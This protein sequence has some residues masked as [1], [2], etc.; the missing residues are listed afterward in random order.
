[1]SSPGPSTIEQETTAG[2]GVTCTEVPVVGGRAGLRTERTS[3]CPALHSRLLGLGKLS[4]A[5]VG[6][7]LHT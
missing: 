6:L 3:K 7:G 2:V 4:V 5:P 1:M